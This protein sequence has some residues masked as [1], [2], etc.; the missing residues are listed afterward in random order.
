MAPKKRKYSDLSAEQTSRIKEIL[1]S[2][3]DE[4]DRLDIDEEDDDVRELNCIIN[5]LTGAKVR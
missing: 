5:K 3:R 4:C 1:L 2:F